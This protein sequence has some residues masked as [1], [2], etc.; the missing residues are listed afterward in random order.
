MWAIGLSSEEG[1]RSLVVLRTAT[2]ALLKGGWLERRA[3]M[4]PGGLSIGRRCRPDELEPI[5]E[6]R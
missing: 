1:I 6:P 4:P 5:P 3:P 2:F